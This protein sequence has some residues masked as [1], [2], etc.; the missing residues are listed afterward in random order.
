MKDEPKRTVSRRG[1]MGAAASTALALT[2]VPSRVLGQDAPGNKLNIAAIGAGGRGWA[3][4]RRVAGENVVALCD[5]DLEQGKK[6]IDAF[7]DAK[8]YRDFRVM[9]D[10]MD[11]DIDAVIVATPDH[12]HYVA[13]MAAIERGKHVY[14][15][16]PLAHSLYETRTITEAARMHKVVTQMGNQG[17]SSDEI[18]LCCEAIWDG[19]I[20]E[21]REVHAWSNRPHEGFSFPVAMR[22]PEDTP[23]VPETLNWDLWL[24]PGAYRPYHPAYCPRYWRGWLDFG[25]GAL[26]DYGCHTLDPAF[27]ALKLGAPT[28][29]EANTTHFEEELAAETYPVA[30]IIR[31]EFP[32]RGDLPP[33]KLTWFDGGLLPPR[34][35]AHPQHKGFGGNGAFIIGDKGVIMH[36]SHGAGGCKILPDHK[37]EEHEPPPRALERVEGGKD[38]HQQD[39]VRACKDG[40]PASGSFDYGGPLTEVVMLGVIAMRLKDQKLLWD[41]E[42]ME[43]T[44]SDEATTL[45][46]PTYREGW[47]L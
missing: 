28:S 14:C 25:T 11:K 20:G 40:K 23:P 2:V 43:F 22:R 31:Y 3:N 30:S 46:K 34:P 44:N 33:V 19:A 21:V 13:V 16:K 36:G 18:R 41:A 6:G 7:P 9:L 26:G 35:E 8:I 27:W 45:V 4:L 12:T 39:W 15:E 10:E 1:F 17:H 29:V 24:G 47:T 38:G 42:S 32:A 37:L 5:V